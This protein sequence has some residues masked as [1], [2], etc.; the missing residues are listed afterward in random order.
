MIWRRPRWRTSQPPTGGRSH[1]FHSSPKPPFHPFPLK[2]WKPHQSPGSLTRSP[3][4]TLR[5]KKLVL[6]ALLLGDWWTRGA[7]GALAVACQWG[8]ATSTVT[9]EPVRPNQLLPNPMPCVWQIGIGKQGFESLAT[10]TEP[11]LNYLLA[12]L[13]DPDHLPYELSYLQHTG[14]SE[15]PGIFAKKSEHP[16]VPFAR[17][18]RNLL[19][20][21]ICNLTH[22]CTGMSF[23]QLILIISKK[24]PYTKV[25]F[26]PKTFRSDD[27]DNVKR[28]HRP[29][30]YFNTTSLDH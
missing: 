30:L 10:P 7:W 2:T 29:D 3:P 17:R 26:T 23:L 4:L 20:H 11:E 19:N 28:N 25:L 6:V 16:T 14:K 22:C 5:G 24:L 27:W 13:N 18:Q 8:L 1:P 15:Y 12:P 9:V 21:M